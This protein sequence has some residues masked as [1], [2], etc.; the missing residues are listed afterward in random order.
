M[1]MIIKYLTVKRYCRD[2]H[3]LKLSLTG[4][5]ALNDIMEDIL[6]AGCKKSK[7]EGHSKLNENHLKN[8]L[9]KTGG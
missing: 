3:N 1:S 9:I 4:Y 5:T 8:L 7:R 6:A 2:K